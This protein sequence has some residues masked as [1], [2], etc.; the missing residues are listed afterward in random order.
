M[1]LPTRESPPLK[2][3]RSVNCQVRLLYPTPFEPEREVR[4]ILVATT[5]ERE[6]ISPVAVAR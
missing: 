1:V 3:K 4:A 5:P 6:R 2:V